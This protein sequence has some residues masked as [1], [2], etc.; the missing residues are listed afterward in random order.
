M[1]QIHRWRKSEQVPL[2]GPK[3]SSF[4]IISSAWERERE[5]GG[6]A[7][8]VPVQMLR[9]HVQAVAFGHHTLCTMEQR[10]PAQRLPAEITCHDPSCD[11]EMRRVH[12]GHL[13][14]EHRI[15]EVRCSDL[16]DVRL[17]CSCTPCVLISIL[18][19]TQ[20]L[21][22]LAMQGFAIFPIN[23]VLPLYPIACVK[24]FQ[25]KSDRMTVK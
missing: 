24:L 23:C 1:Q 6:V 25:F 18:S 21:L 20:N 13:V 4:S 3:Q 8:H 12:I 19:S 16:L 2:P 9:P 17:S 7:N 15:A 10:P 22:C 5:G 14:V 11:K